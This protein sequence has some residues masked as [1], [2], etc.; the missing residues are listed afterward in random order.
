MIVPN[1][2]FERFAGRALAAHVLHTNDF[3]IMVRAL[4]WQQCQC[5]FEPHLSQVFVAP[6][7]TCRDQWNSAKGRGPYDRVRGRRR[8][9][10]QCAH[11]SL[12]ESIFELALVGDGIGVGIGVGMVGCPSPKAD[13]GVG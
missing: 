1:E 6:K 3:C 13:S 5:H 12:S 2:F 10:L 11:S 8:T 7:R 9:S 4:R